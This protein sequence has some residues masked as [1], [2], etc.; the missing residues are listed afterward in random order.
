MAENKA[1]KTA[2]AKSTTLNVHYTATCSSM[3]EVYKKFFEELKMG[4]TEDPV[5]FLTRLSTAGDDW[6][7]RPVDMH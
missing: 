6:E 5:T 2:H 4:A 3:R 7:A 1:L